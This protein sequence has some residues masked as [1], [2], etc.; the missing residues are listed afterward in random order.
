MVVEK[1]VFIK[2]NA[3]KAGLN[4]RSSFASLSL[5]DFLQYISYDKL[6]EQFLGSQTAVGTT[7]TATGVYLKA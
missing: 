3:P 6:S 7:E 4:F 5:V 2:K 1:N